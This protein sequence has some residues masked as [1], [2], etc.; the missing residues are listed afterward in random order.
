[1]QKP[2]V[3]PSPR[4]QPHNQSLHLDTYNL[5]FKSILVTGGAGYVGSLLT[6]QLLDLGYQVTVYDTMYFGDDFLPKGNPALKV[7]EGDIRDV[8]K[9]SAALELGGRRTISGT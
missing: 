1:M 7:V 3:T 8:K 4:A 5:M 6:P 2:P 9:L